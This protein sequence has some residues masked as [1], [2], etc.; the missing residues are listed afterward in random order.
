[1]M[2]N[3]EKMGEGNVNGSFKM[4]RTYLIVTAEKPVDFLRGNP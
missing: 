1:M 4:I 2:T 3:E